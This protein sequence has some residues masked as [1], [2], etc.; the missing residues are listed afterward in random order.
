MSLQE[1]LPE[2]DSLARRFCRGVVI[3]GEKVDHLWPESV[4]GHF[5]PQQCVGRRRHVCENLVLEG[6]A[7]GMSALITRPT[8]A[9]T[10]TR[11]PSENARLASANSAQR[12]QAPRHGKMCVFLSPSLRG[13][14]VPA[15]LLTSKRCVPWR[16]L[17]TLGLRPPPCASEL[18]CARSARA[19]PNTR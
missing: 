18:C 14:S 2:I 16:S 13:I 19:R 4:V 9:D 15:P 12:W 7:N 5:D 10:S 1:L 11:A 8:T 3:H 6:R 17:A